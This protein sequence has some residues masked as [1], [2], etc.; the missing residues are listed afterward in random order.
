TPSTPGKVV[1]REGGFLDDI[2]RFDADFFGISPYEATYM[3]PQQRLLLQVT[4]EG[5][6]AAGLDPAKLAGSNTGV[7][8]GMWTN[9]YES[10]VYNSSD[11]LDVLITSGTGRYTSAGRV[12][13]TFDFRGPSMTL[14]TACS[15]SLVAVHLACQSLWSGE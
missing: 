4:W 12:S 2:D 10:L 11:N 14:D 6:E 1:T 13:Y 5:L 3:D 7:F 8:V 15:S 9:D